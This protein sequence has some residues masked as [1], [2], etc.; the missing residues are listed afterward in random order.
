MPHEVMIVNVN[1]ECHVYEFNL[2]T[3]S[4]SKIR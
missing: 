3:F 4:L 1:A 2:A